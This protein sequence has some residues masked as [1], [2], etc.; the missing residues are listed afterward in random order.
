M[1]SSLYD[2]NV[3]IEFIREGV[4]RIDGSTTSLNLVEFPK[5]AL[6]KGLDVIVPGEEDYDESFKIAV[7][8]LKSGTPVPA[9]DIIVAA[10]TLNTIRM[11][12]LRMILSP[13][14]F[15]VN[16]LP[17]CALLDTSTRFTS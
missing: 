7:L 11:C 5:A 13:F 2:T 14:C 8:L 17:D 15:V 9:V 4:T 12:L 10:T 3:L 6:I 16:W 1:E